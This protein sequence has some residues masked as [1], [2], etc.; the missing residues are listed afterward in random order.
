MHVHCWLDHK[1]MKPLRKPV[2]RTLKN[3]K[4]NV[5]YDAVIQPFGMYPNNS[6]YSRDACT[7]MIV[8]ALFT[9]A[10]TT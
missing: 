7:S 9:V 5:P 8:V 6:S 3:L 2:W 10:K 4:R 1:L